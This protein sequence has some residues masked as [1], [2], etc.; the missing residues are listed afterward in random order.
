LTPPFHT[1][2]RDFGTSPVL[3]RVPHCPLQAIVI[4]KDGFLYRYDAAHIDQGPRQAIQVASSIETA[5]SIPLY[6]MPAFDPH[7]RRLVLVSPSRP[8]GSGLRAGIQTY[9]LD[10]GC[11][12]TPS[13]Q[14]H[15][16]R[17]NAGGPPTIAQ[18]VLYLGSGRNGFLR[19]YRLSDGQRLFKKKLGP[20]IFAAPAVARKT[21][22]AGDWGGNVWAFRP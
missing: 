2:D 11:Q 9:I 21:V 5:T 18:G 19:A 1:T 3:V 17:P 6:G 16:D 8:P 13:W 10:G 14:H 7:G 4:N 15:F 22:V 12:L 20:T